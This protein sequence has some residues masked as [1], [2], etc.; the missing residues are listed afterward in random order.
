ML[1]NIKLNTWNEI[2]CLLNNNLITKYKLLRAL[3]VF[4]REILNKLPSKY[5]IL[6]QLKL[7]TSTGEYRSISRCFLTKV[8]DFTSIID[9]LLLNLEIRAEAYN[10]IECTSLILSY[11]VFTKE[12]QTNIHIPKLKSYPNRLPKIQ[13]GGY[14]LPV[15]M[16]LEE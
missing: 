8:R 6:F 9:E 13:I 2:V 3:V 1:N 7:R 4:R 12:I 15:T 16:D 11:R 14:N 5:S 10:Q